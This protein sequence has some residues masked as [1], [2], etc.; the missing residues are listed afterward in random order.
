[1]YGC[2]VVRS[3][4]NSLRG[5]GLLRLLLEPPRRY[6]L[7]VNDLSSIKPTS[8]PI[9]SHQASQAHSELW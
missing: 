3:V 5:G 6:L 9:L 2:S 1:M 8:L 4:V 7:F